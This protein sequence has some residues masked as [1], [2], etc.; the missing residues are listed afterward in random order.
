MNGQAYLK[1]SR[2]TT[3]K[4]WIMSTYLLQHRRKLDQGLFGYYS[5]YKPYIVFKN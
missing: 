1:K 3:I 4:I 5:I 2:V